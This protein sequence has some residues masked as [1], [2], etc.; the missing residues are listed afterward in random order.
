MARCEM[1][2]RLSKQKVPTVSR[3]ATRRIYRED[4]QGAV[5]MS[6][7]PPCQGQDHRRRSHNPCHH[8]HLLVLG[9]VYNALVD[10]VRHGAARN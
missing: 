4:R 6:L 10:V 1:H 9:V 3:L 7:S 8:E 5:L 2:V